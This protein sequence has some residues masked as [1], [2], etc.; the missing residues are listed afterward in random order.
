LLR[1][2]Y[3]LS[4][5]DSERVLDLAW[6]NSHFQAG[7][8]NPLDTAIVE[9]RRFVVCTGGEPLLQF[10]APLIKALHHRGFEIAVETN[11]TVKPP[12]GLDW[13]CVSPKAGAALQLTRGDELKVVVPQDGL[14]PIRFEDLPFEHFSIQPMDGPE[15]ERNT[16]TRSSSASPDQNGGSASRHTK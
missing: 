7:L 16:V 6:L 8:R 3:T 4:G 12:A 14:D 13:I 5:A 9:L 15:R 2:A 11:G 1:S 10:D